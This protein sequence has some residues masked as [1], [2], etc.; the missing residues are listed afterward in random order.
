MEASQDGLC[1]KEVGKTA[2]PYA[3]TDLRPGDRLISIEGRE[4]ATLADYRDFWNRKQNPPTAG[5]RISLLV[6]RDGRSLTMG[7]LC[8][9]AGAG[10]FWELDE[11]GELS[12]RRSGFPE[13]IVH[14]SVLAPEHCGGPVVDMSGKIVGINIA[15]AAR[16]ATYAIPGKSV[17][18][19]TRRLSSLQK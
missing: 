12:P 5:E 19:L 14:D 8:S 4:F 3:K 7:A 13:V 15:R 11:A 18:E 10:I 17:L 9:P 2:L 6:E 16:H 1:V